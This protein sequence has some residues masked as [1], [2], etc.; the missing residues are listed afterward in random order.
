[1]SWGTPH[2]I[3]LKAHVTASSILNEESAASMVIDQKIRILN[4]GEWV[5]NSRLDA[6]GRVYPYPWIQLEWDSIVCINKIVLYDRADKNTHTAAGTLYFS[7]GTS[8]IV[9]T[10]PDD[11]TPKVV[12]FDSK[13]VN[14][15]RFQ[16][17]DGEGKNLGLSEFE[18]YPAPESYE[19]YVSW[20]NP[21]IETAKGRY[22][23]FV[24]GSLPFG[25]ISSAPLTRNIN[26]GGGG[27]N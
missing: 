18:V 27:Y 17:T 10:I 21:F 3:A 20:V 8:I 26:Q 23:F 25:M 1:M 4:K 19:D 2:N 11:G 13:K 22:F 5:S 16:V 6:R 15:V 7:D 24:T 12:E 14:W 9:N